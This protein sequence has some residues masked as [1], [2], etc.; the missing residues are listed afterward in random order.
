MGVDIANCDREPIHIP[1]AVQPH[2]VLLSLRE[3]ELVVV[4]ASDNTA[5]LFGRVV[6]YV[7][8]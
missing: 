5:D 2:G 7:L 4:Q 3:P 1:G 8:G 6:A